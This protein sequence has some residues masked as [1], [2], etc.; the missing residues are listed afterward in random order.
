MEPVIVK[1]AAEV[2][3]ISNGI[4]AFRENDLLK[5]INVSKKAREKCN[6]IALKRLQNKLKAAYG[7]DDCVYDFMD[8]YN[9]CEEYL[10]EKKKAR[11]E[12]R[13]EKKKIE[14]LATNGDTS[15][16]E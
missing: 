3:A 2:I 6:E 10:G 12:S 4:R 7:L 8:A 1:A 11:K 9:H 16:L 5:D 13:E 14:Q 15:A